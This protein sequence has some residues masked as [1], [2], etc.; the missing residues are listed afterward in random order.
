MA[1]IKRPDWWNY[2]LSCRNSHPWGPGRVLVSWTPCPC[3]GGGPGAGHQ[4]VHCAELGCR[5][6][7]YEPPHAPDADLLG[8]K[9]DAARNGYRLDW[10][11]V[12]AEHCQA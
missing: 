10:H 3:G 5:E 12:A 1:D 6:T 8:Q 9:G 11:P 7:W 4:Q 2:P